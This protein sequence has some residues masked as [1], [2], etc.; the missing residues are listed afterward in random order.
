MDTLSPSIETLFE[1]LG[2]EASEDAVDAFIAKNG[3][4]PK[5]V[6]LWNADFWTSAQASLLKQLKEEDAEWSPVVDE[7]DLMLR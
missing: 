2:L 3:P 6:L 5:D 1:Q 4:I 7:L